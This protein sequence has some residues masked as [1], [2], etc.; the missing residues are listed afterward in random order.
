MA[1]ERSS[2]ISEFE[3]APKDDDKVGSS[4][5]DSGMTP[6]DIK[7]VR[8]VEELLTRSKRAKQNY[9]NEWLEFYRF[10][11]G[12]QWPE[13]RPSY[14]HSEVLNMIHSTIQLII[15]TL[16]DNRPNVETSPEEPSDLPFAEIMTQVLRSRWDSELWAKTVSETIWDALVYGTGFGSCEWDQSLLDSLGDMTFVS[17]DPFYL[18]PDPNSRDVNDTFGKHFIKAEP[19][20]VNEIHRKWPKRGKFVKPDIQSSQHE[21]ANKTD[22]SDVKVRN[23]ADNLV[24][25]DETGGDKVHAA[26]QA[27][28][29][30]AWLNSDEMIEYELEKKQDD[31]SFKKAFQQ[32][33]K[34]PNGRKVVIAN[35]ILLEDGHNPYMHGKFP[36][37]KLIDHV[38]PREFWGEGE[39]KQLAGPQKM[40]NKLASYVMD[41]LVLTGNPIW[42][43]DTSSNV[44]T[45]L[46]FNTP[47]AVVE[48]SPGSEVRREQGVSAQ[49][50]IM[51][52][53]QMM[54]EQLEK[55]S[56][57][58][59]V[60]QGAESLANSSGV[61][62]DRLQEAA[63]TKLRAKARHLEHFLKDIGEM[64]VSN[65]LQF[66]SIPRIIRITNR[67]DAPEYFK[68]HVDEVT[69][70]SG[71]K[72]T[73]NIQRVQ[74][75]ALGREVPTDVKEFVIKGNL[76]V[77]VSTGS[78]LPFAK[79]IKS[80]MAF[81]LFEQGIL[82][83]EDVLETIEWPDRDKVLKKLEIRKQQAAEAAQAEAAQKGAI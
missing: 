17:E 46:L 64:M 78:S 44:D 65:I 76:D 52:F 58:N 26:Q 32:R 61:A 20:D 8:M 81:R 60:S 48:K 34:W 47:G 21:G 51:Q 22:L 1:S 18:F 36:Y 71:L 54:R 5:A 29:I 13:A 7:T 19:K 24:E 59:E 75:D 49:P 27:L 38:L 37:A 80:N 12:K 77:K 14:R 31:G 83:E 73:V 50:F 10:M 57:I 25:F 40:L 33:K 69:D 82:D 62:I 63:Q 53:Y 74:H 11:R 9:S 56:G 67:D 79:A 41:I 43:V 4:V 16:T 15:A 39:V 42:V 70:E 68:F 55:I 72:R 30:T 2:Q 66:Y 23:P 35:G 28:L 3:S 6:A 45:D